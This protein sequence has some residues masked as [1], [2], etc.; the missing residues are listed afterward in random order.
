MDGARGK[1]GWSLAIGTR[2]DPSCSVQGVGREVC[3]ECRG[4]SVRCSWNPSFPCYPV[5]FHLPPVNILNPILHLLLSQSPRMVWVGKVLKIISFHPFAVGRDTFHIKSPSF[6]LLLINFHPLLMT[7]PNSIL[8]LL[9]HPIPDP[10]PNEKQR[11]RAYQVA[12]GAA[13]ARGQPNTSALSARRKPRHHL[14]VLWNLFPVPQ[15]R[16]GGAAAPS[17]SRGD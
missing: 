4:S 7:A 2:E 17:V 8:P 9:I 6:L 14:K 13:P 11:S 16:S 3:R 12:W 1:T 10:L 5:K 15:G